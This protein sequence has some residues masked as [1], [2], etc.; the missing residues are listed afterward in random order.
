MVALQPFY[1]WLFEKHLLDNFWHI[2][3]LITLHVIPHTFQ[4]KS[5]KVCL[6]IYEISEQER[7]TIVFVHHHSI[8]G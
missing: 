7:E 8:P 1:D 3:D 2:T 4:P 6:E 5:T